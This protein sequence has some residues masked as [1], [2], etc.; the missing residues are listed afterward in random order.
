M[1]IKTIQQAFEKYLKQMAELPANKGIN[2]NIDY[3]Y[4]SNLIKESF[5]GGLFAMPQDEKQLQDCVREVVRDFIVDKY[6]GEDR[7]TI[8]INQYYPSSLENLLKRHYTGTISYPI[9]YIDASYEDIQ[10]GKH[11]S[12]FAKFT[13]YNEGLC[14][15]PRELKSKWIKGKIIV[16][17]TIPLDPTKG[18]EYDHIPTDFNSE[19]YTLIEGVA[20]GQYGLDEVVVDFG[21]SV[22]DEYSDRYDIGENLSPKIY[23]INESIKRY[24]GKLYFSEFH[25]RDRF[26]NGTKW[27]YEQ[28]LKANDKIEELSEEIKKNNLSPFEA[29]LYVCSW[30]RKN[31]VYNE[32]E[33]LD[34][35]EINNTII[36]AINNGF[37]QCVGFSE[38][39]NVVLNKAGF[40]VPNL[41]DMP[42]PGIVEDFS[43][44]SL[45][46]RKISVRLKNESDNIS[47]NHCQ[48]LISIND[49]KYNVHG[50]YVCDVNTINIAEKL[51]EDLFDELNLSG[52]DLAKIFNTLFLCNID[53]CKEI[54]P[55]YSLCP[56][57]ASD[58]SETLIKRNK[59]GK[60]IDIVV[61]ERQWGDY[62][63]E[64]ERLTGEAIKR[65]GK[66][67]SEQTYIDAYLKIIPLIYPEF[68]NYSEKDLRKYL[69][70]I[71]RT[72]NL[73]IKEVVASNN[74]ES[75]PVSKKP[76]L[77][78]FSDPSLAKFAGSNPPGRRRGLFKNNFPRTNGTRI[79]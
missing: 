12:D 76:P 20:G 11:F 55:D 46:A 45:S 8:H 71:I 75:H 66:A 77:D 37:T 49:D 18:I 72:T 65:Q 29:V 38:L 33:S 19:L 39:I 52:V 34:D 21:E 10:A 51:I 1:D 17:F 2:F 58:S 23:K 16:N 28:V 60:A 59:F 70:L 64:R 68:Q 9:C 42:S 35:K 7:N 43:S 44:E 54:D 50:E 61:D 53:Q 56:F 69:E 25:G 4:L 47:G 63:E 41:T 3:E 73:T 30:A 40:S 57:V 74:H 13:H 36:S 31:V 79:H 6:Q 14:D 62:V 15:N 27:T 22:R 24:G 26:Y 5:E 32:D 78:V 48:S 67:I